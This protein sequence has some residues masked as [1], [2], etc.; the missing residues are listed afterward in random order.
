MHYVLKKEIGKKR[1]IL[2]P[3]LPNL[4]FVYGTREQMGQSE[5]SV[6]SNKPMHTILLI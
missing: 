6:A 4:F 2:Q 5:N 3:L 1:R